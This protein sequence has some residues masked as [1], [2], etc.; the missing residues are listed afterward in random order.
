MTP[1]YR[2]LQLVD[3]TI[4]YWI[5]A[6]AVKTVL[7]SDMLQNEISQIMD[8]IIGNVIKP[9]AVLNFFGVWKPSGR[10]LLALNAVGRTGSS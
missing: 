3:Q 4:L 7:S 10:F 9:L 5:L 8:G 2:Y 6:L 1:H